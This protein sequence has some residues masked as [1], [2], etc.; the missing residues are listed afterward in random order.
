M[1]NKIIVAA[2]CV[3]LVLLL[4]PGAAAAEDKPIFISVNDELLT[5]DLVN[6]VIS[7]DGVYYVPCTVFSNYGLG[8]SYSFFTSAS[9]AYLYSGDKQLFFDLNSGDTFDGDDNHYSVS[10]IWHNGMVLVPLNLMQ[11]FFGGFQYSVSTNEYGSI[12][13]ISTDTAILSDVELLRAAKNTMR[14]YYLASLLPQTSVPGPITPS[15]TPIESTTPVS[16]PTD[17]PH[18]SPVPTTT[19]EPEPSP[20]APAQEQGRDEQT[21]PVHAGERFCLGLVG[22]PADRVLSVL[23]QTGIK[24]CFFLTGEEIRQNPDMVRR[25]GGEGHG[26]GIFCAG[27]DIRGDWETGAELLFEAAR[28]RTLLV[29]A[30]ASLAEECRTI[31]EAEG[32]VYCGST[33]DM[34]EPETA[35]LLQSPAAMVERANGRTLLAECT[36]DRMQNVIS[37]L[38]YL[39]TQQYHV[40]G[41]RETDPKL[42]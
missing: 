10:A 36:G 39:F 4:L 11:Y 13:R 27:S 5:Y 9:T 26:I 42:S 6:S 29:A 35:A 3:L 7:S 33:L 31:A 19:P 40:T 18:T 38:R 25:I 15:P 20:T 28:V 16:V 22:L 41:P 34:A 1:R 14:S 2:V 32:L 17:A 8:I 37:L 24:T 12:L 30:P 21:G 23:N